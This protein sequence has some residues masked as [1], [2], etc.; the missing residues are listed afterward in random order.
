M[1]CMFAR[2][3]GFPPPTKKEKMIKN[4]KV[5][6]MLEFAVKSVLKETDFAEIE[7]NTL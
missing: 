1:F 5:T 2:L 6:K 4:K 3:G 7:C